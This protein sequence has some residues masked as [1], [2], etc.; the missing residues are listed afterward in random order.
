MEDLIT[1]DGVAVMKNEYYQFDFARFKP[2]KLE[3]LA[4][5]VSLDTFNI[6]ADSGK[7]ERLIDKLGSE[8]EALRNGEIKFLCFFANSLKR[9]G[10]FP[11][12]GHVCENC[13]YSKGSRFYYHVKGLLSS[14]YDDF[15][16]AELYNL[17]QFAI[18]KNSVWK[19]P[20]TTVKDIV[21]NCQD[22]TSFILA[23]SKTFKGCISFSEIQ[24]V[25]NLFLMNDSH[26]IFQSIKRWIL[27]YKVVRIQAY[28]EFTFV[29]DIMDSFKDINIVKP[30]FEKFLLTHE[31][32]RDFDNLP[33][34]LEEMFKLIGENLGDA[35]NWVTRNKWQGISDEAK[36][37]FTLW[38]T[39]KNIKYFFGD[40]AG[41]PIRLDFWRKYSHHFYRIEYFKNYD[42]A[43]LLETNRHLFIE[44]AD[45]GALHMY[46]LKK[47]SIDQVERNPKRYSKTAMVSKTLKNKDIA[48]LYLRH[49]GGNWREK[50]EREFEYY[51]YE[52]RR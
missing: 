51:G 26:V 4:R 44:F 41:D 6:P 49:I 11:K 19:E 35:H 8:G 36:Q 21:R 37:I 47:L 30:S 48:D 17:L 22:T 12:F 33:V 42:G 14:Y 50:F 43:I 25:K 45:I 31:E 10:L 23:L 13:F 5:S 2:K 38:K 1:S 32:R 15:N 39:Q 9:E 20:L 18:E 3:R 28:N 40:I 24:N 16:D 34:P 46:Q 7:L 27:E 52:M 29:K